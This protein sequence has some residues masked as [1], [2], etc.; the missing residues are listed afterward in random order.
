MLHVNTPQ[1]MIEIA[2]TPETP[3]LSIK[4]IIYN[5]G[6]IDTKGIK[7]QDLRLS[8]PEGLVLKNDQTCGHYGLGNISQL[9]VGKKTQAQINAELRARAAAID[10]TLKDTLPPV[11][12]DIVKTCDTHNDD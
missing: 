1:G 2:F 7:A 4:Q 12:L 9:L 10:A 3:I 8:T 5:S 6:D 11:L